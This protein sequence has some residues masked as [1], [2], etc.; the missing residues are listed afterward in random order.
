[1]VDHFSEKPSEL[2]T[3]DPNNFRF[4][5]L[6]PVVREKRRY[7]REVATPTES[8]YQY[9][10]DMMHLVVDLWW[11]NGLKIEENEL[12]E[13]MYALQTTSHSTRKHL[14]A[15]GV[16]DLSTITDA[17]EPDTTYDFNPPN[18]RATSLST[19]D[20]KARL[21]VFMPTF[22]KSLPLPERPTSATNST[23]SSI[24]Q[25]SA[26]LNLSHTTP[27]AAS[28]LKKAGTYGFDYNAT[29]DD[30]STIA[31]V[32]PLE[33]PTTPT[34]RP[35]PPTPSRWNRATPITPTQAAANQSALHTPG[36]DDLDLSAL[37][38][39]GGHVANQTTPTSWNKMQTAKDVTSSLSFADTTKDPSELIAKNELLS[40]V[41]LSNRRR[42]EP[43]L[44]SVLKD[45][46]TH[47]SRASF[48]PQKFFAGDD[49]FDDTNS[50]NHVSPAR[51]Q[52]SSI[53]SS[54]VGGDFTRPL[55]S[56]FTNRPGP[57]PVK[58]ALPTSPARYEINCA[59]NPDIF[60]KKTPVPKQA[61][62][63]LEEH[64]PS[65][66]QVTSPSRSPVMTPAVN[67]AVTD[68]VT[69]A[70]NYCESEAKVFVTQEE[71]RLKVRFKLP[72][73]YAS[74]FPGNQGTES[75]TFSSEL[76]MN[77]SPAIRFPPPPVRKPVSPE[78]MS[79]AR[80]ALARTTPR[81]PLK[82]SPLRNIAASF[83]PPKT[84]A[85]EQANAQ[86]TDNDVTP[87]QNTTFYSFPAT[88]TPPMALDFATATERRAQLNLNSFTSSMATPTQQG[89]LDSAQ[90]A[91]TPAFTP[92]FGDDETL[93]MPG[94]DSSNQ[95]TAMRH[96]TTQ[97]EESPADASLLENTSILT[98]TAQLQREALEAPGSAIP[99]ELDFSPSFATPTVGNIGFTLS[100]ADA[101]AGH[102]RMSIHAPQDTPSQLRSELAFEP[103]FATPTIGNLDANTTQSHGSAGHSEQAVDTTSEVPR[104][105]K[106]EQAPAA[107]SRTTP[108][109]T[110]AS[111]STPIKSSFTPV[112]KPASQRKEVTAANSKASTPKSATH[113]KTSTPSHNK[114]S[115]TKA[116]TRNSA[117]E[118]SETEAAP[119]QAHAISATATTGDQHYEDDR[120]FLL[121]FMEGAKPKK[122][123][124]STT[125]SGSP[126]PSNTA[127]Q[128]LGIKSPNAS[129]SPRKRKSEDEEEE[130]ESPMKKK[131]KKTDKPAP[132]APKRP[133]KGAK[134]TTMP[135]VDPY[136][137]VD[138]D[139]P[140]AVPAEK[141]QQDL[142][143]SSTRIRARA[144]ESPAPKSS[145]P[146]PTIKF[147]SRSGAGID[148]KTTGLHTKDRSEQARLAHQT[149]HNTRKNKFDSGSVEATLARVSE[150]ARS[151]FEDEKSDSG[152]KSSKGSKNVSWNDACLEEYEPTPK[153]GK[154]APKR[155]A[156]MGKTTFTKSKATPKKSIPAASTPG[157][158]GR[159]M[160]ARN[161]GMV[162]N[163][164]PARPATRARTRSQL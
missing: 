161:L 105:D 144:A 106:I 66:D 19:A 127:R 14:A 98:P 160:A 56:F 82:G 3:L 83:M 135:E 147:K 132:K 9:Y 149:S 151:G 150:E 48:S 39:E 108:Q 93:I 24:V 41:K 146:Q 8:N 153:K 42:S 152:L 101:S 27:T 74:L 124:S 87:G 104:D 38:R 133:A 64:T 60:G 139:M 95:S 80:R 148:N 84:T 163:G 70:T 29:I 58:V 111:T 128:P 94:F 81:Q 35:D 17:T 10:N 119:E 34:Q 131:V 142:K 113:K 23:A 2:F 36:N 62:S 30:D 154:A 102:S 123:R 22:G 47:T 162:T 145:L 117:N 121:R 69:L 25:H 12:V 32:D 43:L 110:K 18:N 164:T 16:T 90:Q 59:E 6:S 112:N 89:V 44:Q 136:E 159:S 4:G 49:R 73:K 52:R 141:I 130:T 68:L 53:G 86:M 54:F 91:F 79:P 55:G 99:S 61:Y 71:G 158:K 85:S 157:P 72:A 57:S 107:P 45:R 76:E 118:N 134:K 96:S 115:A 65:Q 143:R 156:T 92:T 46:A 75:S 11:H 5:G 126:I 116:S 13:R 7:Y 138:E 63:Q 21:S 33:N 26:K 97:A 120:K 67:K 109:A 15:A 88:G 137:I 122:P 20:R 114:P 50:T 129:P 37:L 100:V 140:L 31:S 40:P 77:D 155:K 51:T 103:S 78:R 1:M 125:E 28:P